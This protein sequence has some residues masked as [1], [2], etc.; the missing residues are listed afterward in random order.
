MNNANQE[1]ERDRSDGECPAPEPFTP[2]PEAERFYS[3]ATPR[4]L[5]FMIWIAL[6]VIAVSLCIN[7][8]LAVGLCIGCAISFQNFRWLA[9]AVNA[10]GDRI[11]NAQS[12]ESGKRIV[13]KFM[14]RIALMLL[15]AYVIFKSSQVSPRG[16]LSGLFLPSV[17]YGLLA[18]LFLPVAAIVCEAAYELFVATRRG[19]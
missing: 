13:A 14:I 5:R 6:A 1:S 11:V 3:A 19:L 15:A 7:W 10:L 9:Q 2:D 12:R 8:H 18:G 17:L 16:V 4:I